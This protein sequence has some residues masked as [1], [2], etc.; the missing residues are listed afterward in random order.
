MFFREDH[1]LLSAN[2]PNLEFFNSLIV[3]TFHFITK[4]IRCM[5]RGKK[6]CI[7]TTILVHNKI[8]DTRTQ[9]RLNFTSGKGKH[10]HLLACICTCNCTSSFWKTC[11]LLSLTGFG[12]PAIVLFHDY[13]SGTQHSGS[14]GLGARLFPRWANIHRYIG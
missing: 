8:H 6:S 1:M 4:K 14:L 3:L 9:D 13:C 5:C 2:G 10:S 7:A 11:V 12:S